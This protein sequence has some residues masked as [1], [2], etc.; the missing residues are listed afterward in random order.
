[1]DLITDFPLGDDIAVTLLVLAALSIAAL[2]VGA[3]VPVR[4]RRDQDSPELDADLG[5]ALGRQLA[6]AGSLALWIGIP[7]LA[8]LYLVP[9]STDTRILRSAFMLTGL[10]LGLVAGWRG[11]AAQ[12]AA[13]A[14]PAERRLALVPRLGAMLTT[15]ALAL[16]ILP[17]ALALWFLQEGAASPLIGLA[18]GAA[19]S[20][21]AL[22]ACAVP[23]D[24][25]AAAS[26]VLVGADENE[27]EVDAEKN[28]G[29]EHLRAAR[30]FRRGAVQ[31]AEL[32]ALVLALAGV[33]ILLGVAVLAGEG[34]LVVL[35]GLGV[36]MLAAAV[37][38]LVPHARRAP[39][40][41]EDD[42][43]DLD[44]MDPVGSPLRL[45]LGGLV[46]AVL[47]GIGMIVAAALWLPSA[48][49][50]LRF[51]Q[52]G[53]DTFT[54]TAIVGDTPTARADL[55][56]Q[57]LSAITDMSQWTTVT[58][59]SR[60]AGAFLDVLALYSVSP[61]TVAS[62]ALGLGV[63]AAL[64]A[65]LLLG[66]TGDRRGTAVLRAARTSRTGGALGTASALGSGALIA[67]GGIGLVVLIAGVIGVLSAG[68]PALALALLAY[69]GLG[70][71][72]VVVSFSASLLAP[73][74]LERPGV[75]PEDRAA[76]A[77]S[78]VGP[79]VAMLLAALLAGLAALGPIVT[80]M[81]V[82]DRAATV[83]EERA[84]HALTSQSVTL[85][86]GAGLG[87]VTLLLVTASLLEASRRAGA[88]AVVETRAALLEKRSTAILDEVRDGIRR[89]A[90]P[91]L[92]IVVLMPL[93]AGFGLGPSAL[94][95][96][97]LGLLVPAAGWGLWTIASAVLMKSSSDA[98][99]DGRY[100]GPGS[101]GHSG[102]LGGAVLTGVLRSVLGSL[103][104]PTILVT[105]LVSA[106]AV[107]SA[108]SVVTGGVTFYLRWGVALLA[109][110]LMLVC[111]VSATTAPEVD[112]EDG[113]EETSRPL[114]AKDDESERTTIDAM[115]WES[116][117]R[118]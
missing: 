117:G 43:D 115:N 53:M 14:V 64:A 35:L 95:G 89:A 3:I 103:A 107:S 37:V 109:L 6:S 104:L 116:D 60:D 33:G 72:V 112:L 9:G 2:V 57:I 28:L 110:I 94:P 106:L 17:V 80:A 22:R 111:W 27:L 55:E 59:D 16:G 23:M 100:G 70:A 78:A 54:D 90:L 13:L 98:I 25:A 69:A 67:A 31:A 46:P 99:G 101:W 108:T 93:V 83:W 36:A 66:R 52:V 34:I 40:P 48:Y 44:G 21:L 92:V 82:A 113:V 45:T 77:G 61:A 12:L 58:D 74:L 8:L 62:S 1:M 81:Q 56:E 49:Q 102:A 11:L 15:G 96:Y 41:G 5:R 88:L 73:A 4:L 65:V 42:E 47:G 18:A 68:V 105:A 7:A 20:A 85:I 97:V 39:A 87:A 63:L 30:V 76:G 51:A 71:L 24:A 75:D 19:I 118:R 84:L 79:Q 50:D 10:L 86:A 29:A 114:F 26:A 91:A 38:A 32:T